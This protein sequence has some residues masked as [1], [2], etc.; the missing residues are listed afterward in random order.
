MEIKSFFKTISGEYGIP[1][2]GS[3]MSSVIHLVVDR[4]MLIV[5]SPQL[6]VFIVCFYNFV[7]TQYTSMPTCV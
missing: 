5:I 2:C 3:C 4:N 1:Y 6:S 7:L